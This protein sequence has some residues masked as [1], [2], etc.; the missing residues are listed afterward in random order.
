MR[1]SFRM[2]FVVL[3]VS[4]AGM[5]LFCAATAAERTY[6]LDEDPIR[7]GEKS[8]HEGRVAEAR[9]HFEA[10]LASS[11][12]RARATYGLAEVA[13]RE[14]RYEDAEPLYREAIDIRQ[15]EDGKNYP[16]ARAGLG[17]LLLRLSRDAEASQELDRALATD[18][19]L[20]DAIYGKARLLLRVEAWDKAR[21]L[22]ERGA[23]R[24][25]V[26]EGEDKYQ[27]GMALHALGTSGPDAAE[28]PALLALHLNP[29]DP[30]YGTLVAQIYERRNAPTLAIE[31]YESVLQTPGTTPTAPML[32]NLGR[33]YASV[34]QYNEARDRY[35]EAVE[36]DSTYAPA[37]K[38]LAELYELGK[39]HDR[40]A[41]IYLRYV[42]LEPDD[43]DALVGL[44]DACLESGRYAQAVEAATT[45]M[46]IDSTRADAR[47]AFAVAG[48]H[49]RDPVI[50][51][52]AVELCL[53]GGG[54]LPLRAADHVALASQLIAS[55]RYREAR[56]SLA[57]ART[58][59]PDLSDVY[60]QSGMLDL[61]TGDP[62]AATFAFREAIRL[63]PDAPIY[64]LNLGI[65]YFQAKQFGAAVGP[66][67]RAVELDETLTIARL[68]LAQ[69]L[70]VNDS[71]EEAAVEYRR[72][73]EA[74][75][76]NAKA[77]RGLAYCHIREADY[78]AAVEA[79]RAAVDADPNNADGWAGLGNAYLGMQS[80]AAAGSAFDRAKAIDPK[81]LTMQKGLELLQKA[82]EASSGSRE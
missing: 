56:E 2:L 24:K 33:L 54:T 38:D 50:Q 39:Q 40:S 58:L 35:L 1:V 78:A 19:K 80:W 25:G 65:A 34:S 77:L 47:A 74:E 37:L 66:F 73:L 15:S 44:A 55:Q 67:R 64:H 29:T 7:L 62:D 13:M 75:P 5:G 60:F 76:K 32:T 22:L 81:N 10:A 3:L 79:Y 51:R 6:A 17:L 27:Y 72:V 57:R 42:L 23:D 12:Q 71:L 59:D 82:T 48:L 61:E 43:V 18:G 28:R 63:R 20:W 4:S 52:R 45:A 53:E 68:L 41:R 14:G 46:A 16:E 11:Y 26:E 49:A 31:A 9:A 70:A 30:E 21:S 69:A 8:L 36:I